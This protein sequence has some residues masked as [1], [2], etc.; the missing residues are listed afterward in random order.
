MKL[1]ESIVKL[2]GYKESFGDVD[3]CVSP[4]PYYG[5]SPPNIPIVYVTVT[6]DDVIDLVKEQ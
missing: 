6:R 1:S 3:L 4:N 2:E 5:E